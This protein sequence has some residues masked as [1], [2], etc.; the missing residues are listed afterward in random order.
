MPLTTKNYPYPAGGDNND[1]PADIQALAEKNTE[2][3]G[4]R[5][6]TEVTRD[7][8]AGAELW[9]GRVIWN[10][11]AGIH[12]KWDGATWSDI[13][14]APD[15]SNYARKDQAQTFTED[16]TV[17]SGNSLLL[18]SA[19]L[20]HG[21][22]ADS[23]EWLLNARWVAPNYVR[24]EAINRATRLEQN[25]VGDLV[26]FTNSDAGNTVGSIITWAERFRITKAGV[27]TSSGALGSHAALAHM[28][29][30]AGPDN[31]TAETNLFSFSI[32]G[33]TLGTTGVLRLTLWGDAAAS[34]M[35][36][37]TF[38]AKYG[39]STLQQSNYQHQATSGNR[40]KW[41]MVIELAADGATNA[42]RLAAEQLTATAHATEHWTFYNTATES[43][44]IGNIA[45]AEN[46]TIDRTLSVTA[47]FAFASAG[48]D[49]KCRR[50]LLE[51]IA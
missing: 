3:P 20:L 23:V 2:N 1:T 38:R 27:V 9:T 50:A 7:G 35:T 47:A 11:T 8:L 39:A 46:S 51:R 18:G 49:W 16:Q 12:Q 31:T 28:T 17:E 41:K 6:M 25:N 37:T 45:I 26:Y 34:S 44:R 24:T 13:G 21:F 43:P 4:I 48:T 19:G 32:P 5:A 22:N 36:D 15:L 30:D 33:G 40:R 10:V 29:A 14:G 42:Q